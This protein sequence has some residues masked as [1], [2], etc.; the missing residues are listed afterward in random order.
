MGFFSSTKVL[1]TFIEEET[2]ETIAV[3]K[4]PIGQLPDSFELETDLEIGDKKYFVVEAKPVTKPEFKATG[5]LALRLRQVPRMSPQD[6]LF[7]LP[8]I[9][10][11]GPPAAGP[12][13]P[14]SGVVV[15][16]EDDWRQREFVDLRYEEQ[17]ATEL[18]SIRRI[19]T[20]ER[21]GAGFKSLH[22]RKLILNPLSPGIQWQ[23]ILQQLPKFETLS[24]VAFNPREA[25][26][27]GA[28]AVKLPDDVL[29]WGIELAAGLEVLCVENLGNATPETLEALHKVAI[30]ANSCLVDW[31]RCEVHHPNGKAI[32]YAVSNPLSRA[33]QS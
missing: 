30:E 29:L 15:L 2:G 21:V 12:S 27:T 22:I 13:A 17:I 14:V 18:L 20:E 10:N 31:C 16:H 25:S 19:H 8:S 1:V 23:T 24:G 33:E 3:S 7:S 28:V 5:Q 9:S 26:V 4:M 32:D 11:Q 6:I